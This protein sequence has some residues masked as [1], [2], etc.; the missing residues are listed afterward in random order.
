MQQENILES[1]AHERVEDEPKGLELTQLSKD[2]IGEDSYEP[3]E[4]SFIYKPF[5]KRKSEVKSRWNKKNDV[6]LF[7]TIKRLQK[8]GKLPQNFFDIITVRKPWIE[9]RY[10]SNLAISTGWIGP[11]SSLI[12]RIRCVYA[13]QSSMSIREC[14]LLRKIVR[15]EYVGRQIDYEK[16]SI[17]FP[18]KSIDTLKATYLHM[19]KNAT[20]PDAETVLTLSIS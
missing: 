12:N 13:K 16:L 19:F 17:S 11:I 15:R 8:D 7:N 6:L 1:E 3:S 5:G 9:R 4:D 10:L 18:G 20:D 14:K 2:E